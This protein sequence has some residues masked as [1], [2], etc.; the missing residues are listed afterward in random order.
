MKLSGLHDRFGGGSSKVFYFILFHFIVLWGRRPY[1]GHSPKL[2]GLTPAFLKLVMRT[3]KGL[4]DRILGW[5][6]WT[7]VS[8]LVIWGGLD[9]FWQKL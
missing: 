7:A 8:V 4:L 9:G 5:L 3:S 6:C 2:G 1:V